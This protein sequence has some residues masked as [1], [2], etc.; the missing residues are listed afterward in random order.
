MG[1]QKRKEEIQNRIKKEKEQLKT[2]EKK[3]NPNLADQKI[4][5]EQALK[6]EKERMEKEK[7][8]KERLEKEKLEKERTEKEKREKEKRE[9]EKL[10]KEKLEKER[11]EKEKREKEHKESERK[12]KEMEPKRHNSHKHSRSRSRSHH[13]KTQEFRPYASHHHHESERKSGKAY[14]PEESSH[15]HDESKLYSRRNEQEKYRKHSRSR[16][17][18]KERRHEDQK[19]KDK[20][21]TPAQTASHAEP[22]N[23]KKVWEESLLGDAHEE[24]EREESNEIMQTDEQNNEEKSSKS[25][26]NKQ[27]LEFSRSRTPEKRSAKKSEELKDD[28]PN[29][30]DFVK[31][32]V[33]EKVKI[34]K[35]TTISLSER[36]NDLRLNIQAPTPVPLE[37]PKIFTDPAIVGIP[38]IKQEGDRKIIITKLHKPEEEKTVRKAEDLRSK[39]E[40]LRTPN[41]EPAKVSEEV[42]K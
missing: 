39:I 1:D 13:K 18:S 20:V 19:T 16:S 23:L 14:Y 36:N 35:P 6:A 24:S 37:T 29:K 32:Y 26:N 4:K 17:K 27:H 11:V 2:D 22:E 31:K 25:N 5:E 21:P 41:K 34:S 15:R 12:R 38:I 8:E 10:E 40:K 28:N 3:L 7:Q 9:K 33:E 42:P 30:E